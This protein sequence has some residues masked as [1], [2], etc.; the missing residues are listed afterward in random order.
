MEIIDD[1]YFKEN[2]DEIVKYMVMKLPTKHL[3][4]ETGNLL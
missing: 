2:A 4:Q 3:H 1:K